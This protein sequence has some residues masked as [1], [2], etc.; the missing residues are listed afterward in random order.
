VPR[1]ELTCGRVGDDVDGMVVQLDRPALRLLSRPA[2]CMTVTVGVF[3]WCG[4]S[5][6]HA[7]R[8]WCSHPRLAPRVMAHTLVGAG[9]S[10]CEAETCRAT[11]DL[12]CEAETCRARRR[13]VGGIPLVGNW[14]EMLPTGRR[15]DVLPVWV[16]TGALS[17]PRLESWP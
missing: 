9:E 11:G 6:P 7:F 3:A 1:A 13:L 16:L 2:A 15:L 10:S 14:S 4:E 12:S 17:P 8:W 5:F